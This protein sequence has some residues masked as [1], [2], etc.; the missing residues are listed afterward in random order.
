MKC[1]YLGDRKLEINSR[2]VDTT[3]GRTRIE[4]SAKVYDEKITLK[5]IALKQGSVTDW[6]FVTSDTNISISII[7]T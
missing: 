3:L 4:A 6:L 2:P 1:W 7:V 5:K